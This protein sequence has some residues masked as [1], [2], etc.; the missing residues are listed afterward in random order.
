MKDGPKISE[1]CTVINTELKY[2]ITKISSCDV[3]KKRKKMFLSINPYSDKARPSIHEL[4]SA[5]N[6]GATF[7]SNRFLSV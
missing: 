7:N 2:K 5:M 1:Y 6:T 3:N 4:L